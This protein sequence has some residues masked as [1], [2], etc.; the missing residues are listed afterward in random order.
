MSE[1]Q[2]AQASHCE[3]GVMST[4]LRH[5]GL[6]IS[7]PMA[8]G[9]SSAISFAY[10]PIVRI[11]GLPLVAYRMPPKWII[12]GLQKP[13]ALKMRFETF[14]RPEDGVR[15]L[16]QLLADGQVVGLQTSVYWLPYLPEDLRFHFNAHNI[17]AF[18]KADD[19]SYR[20]SDP[21]AEMTVTCPP[22]A[23]QRA[24][25]AKGVLAPKG[26]IYY[27][28]GRPQEPAWEKVVPK[29]IVKTARIMLDSPLPIIGVRGIR[30][31]AAAIERLETGT[32]AQHSKLFIGQVVRM[33][34]E[35]GTGGGGFRFI[36]A[37]FLQEA[38]DR[39]AR[40]VLN[41]LADTLIDIG[42]EWREFALATA[43]MIRD[44]DPLDPPRL[45]DKLRTIAHRE[46]TFFRDLRRAA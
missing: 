4:M 25:F 10:L 39:L 30:R 21:V 19:G 7:E 29:A 17:L 36:Y 12:K 15:R 26:L 35:I 6:A 8:F 2:H 9:L 46:Q 42:D 5:H 16:D 38:A 22:D 37:S 32:D 24:R 20:I 44:R 34:E 45:A 28:L 27:P 40:P 31:L 23:L 18:G 11:N 43:R 41:E 13:L 1:L 33:Q 3:S 14:R